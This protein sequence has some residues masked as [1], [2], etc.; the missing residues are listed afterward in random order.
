M[1]ALKRNITEG[2]IRKVREVTNALSYILI[3]PCY[4]DNHY[5]YYCSSTKLK[6]KVIPKYLHYGDR[7]QS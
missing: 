7:W 4:Q 5:Q 1:M 3:L 6:N 2:C